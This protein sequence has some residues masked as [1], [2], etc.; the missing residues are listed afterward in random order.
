MGELGVAVRHVDRGG[1][2]HGGGG[3]GM[4]FGTVQSALSVGL[5]KV[6]GVEIF[7]V[8]GESEKNIA[9]EVG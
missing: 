5:S 6:V 4:F 7:L 3:S 1:E 8:S 9:C 2:H